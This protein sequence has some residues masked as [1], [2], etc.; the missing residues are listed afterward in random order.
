MHPVVEINARKTMGYVALK[1]GKIASNPRIAGTESLFT[2][3]MQINQ[4][5]AC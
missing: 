1:M 3:T 4:G 2:H 5:L